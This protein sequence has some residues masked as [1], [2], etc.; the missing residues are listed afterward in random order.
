MAAGGDGG[1]DPRPGGPISFRHPLI[2]SAIYGAAPF[3]ERRQTH[4]ALA[5]V[6]V[7]DPDR[8]AWQLSAATVAPDASV[9]AALEATAMRAHA[10]GAMAEA[11][12]GLERAAQLNSSA[13]EQTR[14][15]STAAYAAVL[16]GDIAQAEALAA[17][18][19]ELNTDPAALVWISGLTGLVEMLMMRM[20][21][22]FALVVPAAPPG[23]A[24]VHTGMSTIATGV[25]YHSGNPAQ[26]ERLV[27]WL[28]DRV[29]DEAQPHPFHLW[30]AGVMDPFGRGNAIRAVL[31]TVT[32]AAGQPPTHV[33]TLGVL[34]MLLDETE[35]AVSLLGEVANPQWEHADAFHGGMTAAD[36]A[37]ANLD[38]GQWADARLGVE[39]L[40]QRFLAGERTLGATRALTV[41]ADPVRPHRRA[42]TRPGPRH[43]R[44]GR[45]RARLCARHR[46][47]PPPRRGPG[48]RGLG[49]HASAF[50]H[51]RALFDGAGAPVH[52]HLSCY[53]VAD[54]AAAAVL[55]GRAEDAEAVLRC[56]NS[57]VGDGP[58][59]VCGRSC[60]GPP[61]CSP[62]LPRPDRPSGAPWRT[63][64]AGAGRSST[65]RSGWSTGSGCAGSGR[66]PRRGSA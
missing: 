34:C 16:V 24:D 10:R 46:R 20:E 57:E 36:L 6:L 63:R 21:R 38:S 23:P 59:P 55:V 2:R 52:F 31:P 5:A 45:D 51:L 19:T 8:R 35:A 62:S 7:G 29:T 66:S 18:A 3:A 39:R 1:A 27:R 53:A 13:A 47:P 42:P 65:P 60:T 49:D 41:L 58:H 4:L 32:S 44:A 14:L 48:G 61:R 56:V 64:W 17:R 30:D 11:V 28:A 43:C 33:H 37:W 54:F 12:A 40:A 25:A 22:A 26:R 15:L 50:R 9:S